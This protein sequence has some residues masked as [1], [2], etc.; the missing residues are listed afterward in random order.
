MEDKF[1]WGLCGSII[2]IILNKL[3]ELFKA[4]R[5]NKFILQK[6]YFEKKII[7]AE[8]AI[9]ALYEQISG[10][11][12]YIRLY[13]KTIGTK[14]EQLPYIYKEIEYLNNES[15][16]A[17]KAV[18]NIANTMYLYFDLDD[19][20]DIDQSNMRKLIDITLEIRAIDYEIEL[21]T[22]ILNENQNNEF[23]KFIFEEI[24]KKYPEYFPKLKELV[25]IG[26][27]AKA[28]AMAQL[29]KIKKEMNKQIV[30]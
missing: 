24:K 14:V 16:T 11:D 2:T 10:I 3:F 19:Y 29:I 13:E 5:D 27:K 22:K 6:I 15:K 7:S 4:N 28:D 9:I 20:I 17:I 1:L 25:K 30:K 23:G 26:Y 21:D 12:T 8:S 18:G